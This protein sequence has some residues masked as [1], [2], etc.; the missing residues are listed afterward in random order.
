VVET[1][2]D[3]LDKP[4]EVF[5]RAM[6]ADPRTAYQESKKVSGGIEGLFTPR[7]VER[8]VRG[9]GN[10]DDYLN[11]ALIAAP[12]AA[13]PAAR[14]LKGAAKVATPKVV[15]R[16]TKAA[17]KYAARPS[18][19]SDKA[20]VKMVREGRAADRALAQGQ[21]ALSTVAEVAPAAARVVLPPPATVAPAE[22]TGIIAYHGSPHSFDRFDISKIGTGEGAQAYGHGLYFAEA[23][24]VARSYKNTLAVQHNLQIPSS[25]LITDPPSKQEAAAV[26]D[27]M[28]ALRLHTQNIP[29]PPKMQQHASRWH[30]FYNMR[31]EA[32]KADTEYYKAF[33]DE[34][35]KQKNDM[36]ANFVNS[37]RGTASEADKLIQDLDM[38]SITPYSDAW[39]QA[40]AKIGEH[41]GGS[42]Y[43]VRIN[44]DPNRLLN[45]DQ[46]I[47]AQSPELQQAVLSAARD[48]DI[49]HLGSGHRSRVKLER[50]MDAAEQPHDPIKGSELMMAID[51][52]P[53]N[54]F[55]PETSKLLRNYGIPGIKYLDQGSRIAGDGSRN[56]VV[57]DDALI[58]LLRKYAIG[59]AVN[60]SPS[61]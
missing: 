34:I 37:G 4:F 31:N 36:I 23:E 8:V 58:D 57:F 16:G 49:S 42:M 45:W 53:G 21:G 17:V 15:Q 1:F 56:Y 40:A 38:F 12:F 52:S 41:A 25:R 54:N 43:Q 39:R 47:T 29:G 24:P 3:Y 6:G 14:L 2:Y 5:H 22:P 46:P 26:R 30:D 28:A 7:S 61:Q 20:A 9:Q 18:Y 35:K 51:R 59:G 19:L 13:K 27:A 55:A 32:S 48:A 50:F 44:A 11:A 60:P 33:G 10:A